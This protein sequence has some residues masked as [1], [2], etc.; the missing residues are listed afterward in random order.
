MV[1]E[2]RRLVAAGVAGQSPAATALLAMFLVLLP[3]SPRATAAE[4][5]LPGA[6]PVPAVEVI[7]LPYD[8]ASFRHS[9]RELTRYHFGHALRRPFWYPILG[10]TNRSASAMASG[11]MPGC[12][13]GNRS[14]SN[15]RISPTANYRRSRG[16]VT[17]SLRGPAPTRTPMWVVAPRLELRYDE[18][19]ADAWG[20]STGGEPHAAQTAEPSLHI[21]GSVADSGAGGAVLCNGVRA[22]SA[23]WSRA[24]PGSR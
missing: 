21:A 14:R 11:S 5:E 7:P 15:G 4:T 12:L 1:L 17:E 2:E 23:A 3:P 6:K 22:G 20:S 24:R 13:S 19:L 18:V 16:P 9:D 10:P 8:R